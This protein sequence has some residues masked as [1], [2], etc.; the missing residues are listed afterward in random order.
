MK[1]AISVI[2]PALNEEKNIASAI[3]NVLSAIGNNFSDY[4]IIVFDDNSSDKTRDI[5][6]KVTA[7]NKKI[8]LIHNE[9]TMGFGYNYRKGV[10]LARLEYISMIPGD[11]EISADSIDEMY[12]AI[13]KADI[14][15]P[16]TLNYRARPLLRRL[17][18]FTFTKTLNFIFNQK[19]N[20]Y[21]GP[22]IHRRELIRSV[23]LS[24]NSFAFQAE[25]LV[26]LIKSGHSYKQVGMLLKE[27]R[28]GRS[29]AFRIKN[30][31][32]VLKTIV[33]LFIE[34][35]LIKKTRLT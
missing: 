35:Y 2:I 28:Y 13:G 23:A 15:V 34:V 1:P 25:A 32:G 21:N 26:K 19:L 33:I 30:I 8:R 18:S 12:R 24:T 20:Y 7:K 16:Y 29:K 6:E 4:E 10:E 27:R 17:I 31:L 22:V 9:K 3:E 11:D 5:V 14:V